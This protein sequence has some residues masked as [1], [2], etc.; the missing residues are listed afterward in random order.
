MRFPTVAFCTLTVLLAGGLTAQASDS[1][2]SE[3]S[4]QK[5][6]VSEATSETSSVTSK[7]TEVTA[8]LDQGQAVP[9]YYT[10]RGDRL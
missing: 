4:A 6:V 5:S 7:E 3:E 8:K 9:Y 1:I 10:V 2:T